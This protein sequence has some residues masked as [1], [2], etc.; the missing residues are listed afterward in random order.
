MKSSKLVRVEI[1]GEDVILHLECGHHIIVK[2]DDP[3]KFYWE[4]LRRQRRN[5]A[6]YCWVCSYQ[7]MH[8]LDEQANRQEEKRNLLP[9]EE[10]SPE[11]RKQ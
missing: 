9:A 11:R 8:P 2:H 10:D 1:K 6:V 4:Y 3:E 7:S 5:G